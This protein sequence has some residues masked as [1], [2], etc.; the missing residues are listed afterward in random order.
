MAAVT[1]LSARFNV[2]GNRRSQLYRI[3]GGTGDTLTTGL[4]SIIEVNVEPNATNSP[5]VASS[6]GVITFTSGGA[7]TNVGV[8]VIGN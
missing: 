3:S 1:Q 5:T 8:E 2:V 4:N 6:G 7:Y